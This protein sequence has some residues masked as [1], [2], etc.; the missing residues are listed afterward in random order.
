MQSIF[1][2]TFY[3]CNELEEFIIPASV[4]SIGWSA[5]EKCTSMKEISVPSSVEYIGFRVFRNCD[6]NLVIKGYTGSAAESFAMENNMKCQSVGVIKPDDVMTPTPTAEI[7]TKP[8]APAIPT[9]E[10]EETMEAE[11][12]TVIEPTKESQ[13]TIIPTITPESYV[14]TLNANGGI[15]DKVE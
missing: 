9:I 11:A 3:E 12:T 6:A 1:E 7:T 14:I 2:M 4:K 8:T 5:F 10:P 15:T 13:E